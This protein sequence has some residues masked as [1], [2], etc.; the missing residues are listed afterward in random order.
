MVPTG[1]GT[2]PDPTGKTWAHDHDVPD[3]TGRDRARRGGSVW[4]GAGPNARCLAVP[5]ADMRFGIGT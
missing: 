1:P 4:G 5:T 3:G 2:V